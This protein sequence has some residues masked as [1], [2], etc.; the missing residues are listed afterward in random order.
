M[1][2]NLTEPQIKFLEKRAQ[3]IRISVIEMLLEAKSGHTAG[4]LGMADIFTYLYFN[5]LHHDAKNPLWPERDMLVLSNGHICPVLYATLAHAGYFP[6]EELK[7]LRK[8]GSRLQGHPHRGELPGIETSITLSF[9]NVTSVN[10]ISAQV[11]YGTT[12]QTI[13]PIRIGTDKY[14]FNGSDL[15]FLFTPN[16]IGSV[17][18]YVKPIN[19]SGIV[20]SSYIISPV[21]NVSIP[22]WVPTGSG[23]ISSNIPSP[24]TL[25]VGSAAQITFS[26]LLSFFLLK[27]FNHTSKV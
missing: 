7:T 25:V 21:T 2:S 19:L 14:S 6:V 22:S 3:E 11:F 9:S 15:T 16:V 13:N 17:Y 24:H 8:L 12:T 5:E 26:F 10:A 20:Y 27:D 23:T 4:S 1:V 18:F